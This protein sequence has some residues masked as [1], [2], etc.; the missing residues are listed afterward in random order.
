MIGDDWLAELGERCA[1]IGRYG[2]RW[3]WT[4]RSQR[5]VAYDLGHR[6]CGL[7]VVSLGGAFTIV[8][9]DSLRYRP[10]RQGD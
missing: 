1:R 8:G 10:D 7:L 6:I 3:G 9:I 4:E 2:R 5:H